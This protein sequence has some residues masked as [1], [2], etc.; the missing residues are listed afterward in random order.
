MKEMS[1]FVEKKEPNKFRKKKK[2]KKTDFQSCFG[3]PYPK[4]FAKVGVS[5]GIIS[6]VISNKKLLVVYCMVIYNMCNKKIWIQKMDPWEKNIWSVS[7]CVIRFKRKIFTVCR[8][9]VSHAYK[10]M[11]SSIGSSH[12]VIRV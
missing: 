2:K 1:F 5:L 6:Y 10:V 3:H 12:F 8:S 4:L 7:L 9:E 11:P